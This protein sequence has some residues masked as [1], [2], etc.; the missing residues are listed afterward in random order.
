[1]AEVE[2]LRPDALVAHNS[3]SEG[4]MAEAPDYMYVYLASDNE[5]VKEALFNRLTNRTEINEKVRH[6]TR[7][8]N[9]HSTIV[10]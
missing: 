4:Q 8:R 3:S 2:R 5:G 6:E 7:D 9:R 10:D 1:M